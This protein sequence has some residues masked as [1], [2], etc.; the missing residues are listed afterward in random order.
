MWKSRIR[1]SISKHQLQLTIWNN[2]VCEKLIKILSNSLTIC[3]KW[4][5]GKFRAEIHQALLIYILVEIFKGKLLI[6]S[7]VNSALTLVNLSTNQ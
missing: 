3:L 5:D 4:K 1:I 7:K 2:Y 6:K